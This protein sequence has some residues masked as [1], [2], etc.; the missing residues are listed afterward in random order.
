MPHT[1]HVLPQTTT[2]YRGACQSNSGVAGNIC[3]A[4]QETSSIDTT[5]QQQSNPDD[6]TEYEVCQLPQ[7]PTPALEYSIESLSDDGFYD[8]S[9]GPSPA[10]TKTSASAER[11][12]DA[13]TCR[14]RVPRLFNYGLDKPGNIVSPSSEIAKNEIPSANNS[15]QDSELDRHGDSRDSDG[16]TEEHT[17]DQY[18]PFQFLPADLRQFTHDKFLTWMASARYAAPPED[19][20]LPRKRIKTA[21]RPL[22]LALAEEEKETRDSELVTVSAKTGYFHLACPFYLSS[23][24]KSRDCLLPHG[25]HSVE[26][27][28]SHL[29]KA[30]RG[31]P[32]YGRG[33][34][35]CVRALLPWKTVKSH[36]I[37]PM[38]NI[39]SRAQCTPSPQTGQRDPLRRKKAGVSKESR[40]GNRKRRRVSTGNNKDN[41]PGDSDD[42]GSSDERGQSNNDAAEENTRFWACLY[43]A[44]DQHNHFHC[45]GKYKLRRFAD[46]MQHLE[47][48]HR[49]PR[50][51]CPKCWHKQKTKTAQDA[52]IRDCS[53]PNLPP[54]EQLYDDKVDQ[55]KDMLKS[56]RGSA[57]E[58][59]WF[60]MWDMIFPGRP[61]PHS[62]YVE[63]GMAEPAGVLRRNNEP[64]LHAEMP[65]LLEELGAQPSPQDIATFVAEVVSISFQVPSRGPQH[66]GMSLLGDQ[67][68]LT[69]P[70]RGLQSGHA[71]PNI[72]AVPSN[73]SHS[74]PLAGDQV[75]CG[76]QP[77]YEW[78]TTRF[79]GLDE[80]P[81]HI[82]PPTPYLPPANPFSTNPTD[83]FGNSF[84]LF[85]SEHSPWP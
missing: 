36:A 27:A 3:A 53:S 76:T 56:R 55:L 73:P 38:A 1:R 23:P 84:S 5:C 39:C 29:Q 64:A 68:S 25:L 82:G 6:E 42:E 35:S 20:L 19:R 21:D 50:F 12:T 26:D 11:K 72:P 81:M 80:W 16:T 17:L 30:Q 54:P 66:V 7:S 8:V 37:P 4:G 41:N 71:P 47:R 13:E 34:L 59:K 62:P 51:Y 61:R 18:D 57:D 78:S 32:F 46:I 74:Q 48:Y 33:H 14:E 9:P 44:S 69:R 70:S 28:I 67:A 83:D 49:L 85:G 24:D 77:L 43:Y 10:G 65:R 22:R 63:Q 75:H 58:D 79:F 40:K 15:D 45:L 60:S 52:H 31:L 2:S